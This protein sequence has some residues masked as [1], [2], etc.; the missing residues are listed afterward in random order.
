MHIIRGQRKTILN[1]WKNKMMSM[2]EQDSYALQYAQKRAI[3]VYNKLPSSAKC[4]LEIGDVRNEIILNYFKYKDSFDTKRKFKPWAH[5]VINNS[6][7][8][9]IISSW[10]DYNIAKSSYDGTQTIGVEFGENDE[11]PVERILI[12]TQHPE[13]IFISFYEEQEMSNKVKVLKNDV[14]KFCASFGIEFDE[15]DYMKSLVKVL[16]KSLNNMSDAEFDKLPY[17]LQLKLSAY[18]EAIES[19]KLSITGTGKVRNKGIV[20]EIRSCV[21]QGIYEFKEVKEYLSKKK[22]LANEDSIR[23]ILWDERKRAGIK[24]KPRSGVI[25]KMRVLFNEGRGIITVGEMLHQL[26]QENVKC[27]PSTVRTTVQQLR[28]DFGIIK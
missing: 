10:D 18:G 22:Y 5:A 15:E 21:Q 7:T 17:G 23:T 8:D 12:E 11:A 19:S 1:F 24:S 26:D 27:S 13:I 3:F 2:T 16:E 4:L 6:G 25:K 9:L 28:K 20:S 14:K